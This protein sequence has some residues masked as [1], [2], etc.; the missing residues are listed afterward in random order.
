MEL[1][2]SLSMAFC[3]QPYKAWC[4]VSIGIPSVVLSRTTL[5]KNLMEQ[6]PTAD[7]KRPF[8]GMVS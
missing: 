7:I 1:D 4:Q 8:H 5:S 2:P 6:E 3:D